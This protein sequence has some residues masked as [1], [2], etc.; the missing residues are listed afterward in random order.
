MLAAAVALAACGGS[1]PS[2][3]S[4]RTA[5]DSS[6]SALKLAE[7]M[8][9]HGVPNFPD[10]KIQTSGHGVAIAIGGN[11]VDPNAPQFQAAQKACKA[12]QPGG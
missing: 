5:F 9:T 2:K 10:P 7:C 1:S 12:Y 3:A 6:G 11:G 4:R 8:R